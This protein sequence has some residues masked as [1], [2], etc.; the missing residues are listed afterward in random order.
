MTHDN[1]NNLIDTDNVNNTKTYLLQ[2]DEAQRAEL[3]R[4]LQYAMNDPN[5]PLNDESSRPYWGLS[6]PLAG[7]I[8]ALIDMKDAKPGQI[9]GMAP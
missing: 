8:D 1:D 4:V 6:H 3:L 9:Q 2:I 5:S 7:W